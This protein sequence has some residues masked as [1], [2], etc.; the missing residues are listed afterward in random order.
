VPCEHRGVCNDAAPAAFP[1]GAGFLLWELSTP[2]VHYRWFLLK[3]GRSKSRI[4]LIN[5]LIMAV[6]FFACRPVWGT[7][8]SYRVGHTTQR[9]A[10]A[11]GTS[12]TCTQPLKQAQLMRQMRQMRLSEFHGTSALCQPQAVLLHF[13]ERLASEGQ[14]KL[15]CHCGVLPNI[16]CAVFIVTVCHWRKTAGWCL[17][18]TACSFMSTVLQFFKDTEQELHHPSGSFP[19]KW[20]LGLPDCKCGPQPAQLLLVLENRHQGSRRRS[21]PSLAKSKLARSADYRGWRV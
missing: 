15:H 18:F 4:Y 7:Y 16:C 17:F 21:L 5:G 3:A 6:V 13:E 20:H 9:P 2:F 14:Q 12:L 19:S 10:G 11:A 1:A 8:L